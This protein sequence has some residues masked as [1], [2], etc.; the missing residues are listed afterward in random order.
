MIKKLIWFLLS[1]AMIVFVYRIVNS[2]LY[3]QPSV[4]VLPVNDWLPFVAQYREAGAL[5]FIWD[6]E[7]GAQ[8]FVLDYTDVE[9]RSFSAKAR[10]REK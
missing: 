2:E 1:F 8:T 5:S 10:N 9:Q 6:M 7:P 4:P 3:P